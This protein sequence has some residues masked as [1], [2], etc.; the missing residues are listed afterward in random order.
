MSLRAR[1]QRLGLLVGACEATGVDE[2]HP[3]C[4]WLQNLFCL[5]GSADGGNAV[6]GDDVVYNLFRLWG[7]TVSPELYTEGGRTPSQPYSSA[8]PI[9]VWGGESLCDNPKLVV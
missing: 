6:G 5:L 1:C 3:C 7:L 9:A 8:I 2:F 4:G